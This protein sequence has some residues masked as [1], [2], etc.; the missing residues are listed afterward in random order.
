[1]N[2]RRVILAY[3][4]EHISEEDKVRINFDRLTA[5]MWRPKPSGWVIDRASGN[6][7]I[8]DFWGDEED[9]WGASFIFFWAGSIVKVTAECTET[10]NPTGNHYVW[11][12]RQVPNLGSREGQREQFNAELLQALTAM[13]RATFPTATVE[14]VAI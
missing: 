14:L 6:W 13:D 11:R 9:R 12:L 10:R 2:S 5:H 7:V 8:Q 4:F 1:M 3:Q